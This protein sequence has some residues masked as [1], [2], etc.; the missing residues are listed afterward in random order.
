MKKA[1]VIKKIEAVCY[2]LGAALTALHVF[3]WRVDNAGMYY[4]TINEWGIAGG[5]LLLG[6]AWSAKKW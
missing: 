3:S 5:V 4:Q 1:D 6:I 2:P